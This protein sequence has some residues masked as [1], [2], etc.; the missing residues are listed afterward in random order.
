MMVVSIDQVEALICKGWRLVTVLPQGKAVSTHSGSGIWTVCINRWSGSSGVST[1]RWFWHSPF[2]PS[3]GGR[4][5]LERDQN[6]LST[7]L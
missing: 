5:P 4:N 6:S 7:F 1:D 2:L 3:Q